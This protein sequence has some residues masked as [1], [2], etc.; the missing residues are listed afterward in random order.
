M[1]KQILLLLVLSLAGCQTGKLE[2]SGSGSIAAPAGKKTKQSLSKHDDACAEAAKAQAN[3]AMLGGALSIAGGLGGFGGYG[4]MIA[5][6]AASVGGS[7]MQTQA[8]S[9]AK[10]SIAQNCYG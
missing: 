9:K 1:K 3:A 7:V 6:Q 2:S 10:A 5:G 4:G 8:T